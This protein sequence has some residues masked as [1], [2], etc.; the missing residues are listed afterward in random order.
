MTR[1]IQW[2]PGKCT[3]WDGDLKYLGMKEL[4]KQVCVGGVEGK[5]NKLQ[6]DA[7]RL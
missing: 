3:V 6:C 1:D 7:T 4:K 5:N 2:T